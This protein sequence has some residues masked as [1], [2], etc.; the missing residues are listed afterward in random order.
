M[1]AE[2]A[3]AFKNRPWEERHLIFPVRETTDRP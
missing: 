1:M 2:F 3:L